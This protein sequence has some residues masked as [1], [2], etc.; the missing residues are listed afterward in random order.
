MKCGATLPRIKGFLFH[1]FALLQEHNAIDARVLEE[2]T[3]I[4]QLSYTPAHLSNQNVCE[5]FRRRLKT[6][7]TRG[8]R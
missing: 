4:L 5:R 3:L 2:L 7:P 8:E 6:S 1:P